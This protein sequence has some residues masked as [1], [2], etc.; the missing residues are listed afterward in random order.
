MNKPFWMTALAS[1]FLLALLIVPVLRTGTDQSIDAGD[2]K[3]TPTLESIENTSREQHRNPAQELQQAEVIPPSF[4]PVDVKP[5][6]IAESI[7]AADVDGGGFKL[8]FPADSYVNLLALERTGDSFVQLIS[9]E[10]GS[11]GEGEM[12]T[13]RYEALVVNP[14]EKEWRSIPLYERYGHE[15]SWNN[16][17]RAIDD[18]HILFVRQTRTGD[19]LQ[20]DLVRLDVKSDKVETVAPGFW[21]RYQEPNVYVDDFL[22]A[23]WQSDSGDKLLL[24]SF[25]GKMWL[26]DKFSDRVTSFS[27]TFPAYGDTGSKPLRSL[28]YPSPDL[29][30][31]VYQVVNGSQIEP[32]RHFQIVDL[33]KTD[34][35]AQISLEDS[36]IA[37]DGSVVWNGSGTAFFLEYAS[38]NEPMGSVLEN[39]QTV[40]AQG[41]ALYDRNGREIRKLTVRPGSRER[42]NVFGW[43]GDD[44]LLVE[45]HV[46]ALQGE[47]GWKKSKVVY[48]IHHVK[49]GQTTALAT[50]LN[51]NDLKEPQLIRRH[52]GVAVGLSG[53]VLLDRSTKKIWDAGT[54]GRTWEN[55]GE[56]YFQPYS[57][58]ATFLFRWNEET[59]ELEWVSDMRNQYISAFAG[60]WLASWDD[61]G[62]LQFRPTT[63]EPFDV[64]DDL[65]ILPAAFSE[66]LSNGEWWK[67]IGG[68]VTTISSLG[69]KRAGGKGKYGYIELLAKD[70]EQYMLDGGERSYY[71][72]YETV[73]IGQDGKRRVLQPELRELSLVLESETASMGAFTMGEHDLFVLDT[74][75][76]RF[77]RGFRSGVRP[78]VAYAATKS[79]EAWP[80][81][82]QF[83]LPGQ[84]AAAERISIIG[85]S[86]AITSQGNLLTEAVLGTAR[87]ELEWKL[88]PD[89]RALKLTAMRDRSAEYAALAEI[90]GKLS[91]I[92]EQG[93]GLEDI[94]LPEGRLHEELLR[95]FFGDKAW[96]NPGFQYLRKD[97][98][99][100]KE[101]GEPSR[102]FAWKPINPQFDGR[103][104]ISVTFSLNLFHAIGHAAHLEAY[105]KPVNR[106]WQ[107]YDF[108][109]LE[110]EKVDGW[111]GYNGFK[112]QDQLDVY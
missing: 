67:G 42:M 82:F 30:R 23:D 60:D 18:R 96:S 70:G 39:G 88:D 78:I 105:L 38:G 80:L 47:N 90:S 10:D 27:Q 99:A 65:P 98:A 61:D 6:T 91:S 59:R 22:L 95:E 17:F 108:G 68:H 92:M 4:T 69:E 73:Y 75:Q 97:F 84:I 58:E 53:F 62:A 19:I 51:G 14:G 9:Y 106:E 55:E 56:V 111:P 15:Y 72:T 33:E 11:K 63:L 77:N 7:T 81:E 31:M 20:Y 102:A 36:D 29:S 48:K 86:P 109:T 104:N 52:E 34:I 5:K 2:E 26:F 16:L 40:S 89:N 64:K 35:L 1:V 100:Q 76:N 50:V 49:T 57:G 110:T 93:L 8:S 37:G 66:E 54:E 41:I 28:S 94:A 32:S 103:G 101:G 43:I 12:E 21:I 24:S 85:A 112:L 79:G 46:P 25:M 3:R 83:A 107:I 44:E 87:Y 45:H 71:G 13:I 74:D